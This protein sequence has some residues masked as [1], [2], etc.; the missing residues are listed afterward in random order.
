MATVDIR[1]EHGLERRIVIRVLVHHDREPVIVNILA[2]S[3]VRFADSLNSRVPNSEFAV[4]YLS[5]ST[6]LANGNL[7]VE[8]VPVG[9]IRKI[10]ASWVKVLY[11]PCLVLE[12]CSNDCT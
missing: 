7:A 9:A 4:E 3:T 2:A 1:V 10:G 12:L 8:S 6:R 11:L 5:L